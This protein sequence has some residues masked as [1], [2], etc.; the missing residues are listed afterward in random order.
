MGRER[1]SQGGQLLEFPKLHGLCTSKFK[2]YLVVK[3]N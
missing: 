1:M 3:I 2:T